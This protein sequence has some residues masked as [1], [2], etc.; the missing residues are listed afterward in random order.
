M[1]FLRNRRVVGQAITAAAT[2]LAGIAVSVFADQAKGNIVPHPKS[3]DETILSH[4]SNQLYVTQMLLAVLTV[5]VALSASVQ[6]LV[7][8]KNDFND[9]ALTARFVLDGEANESGKTYQE[10][11][12]LINEANES[13]YFVDYWV[14]TPNYEGEVQTES[15]AAKHKRRS[16]YYK[17]IERKIEEFRK[18]GGSKKHKRIIQV[19]A[20][21][22]GEID[23][24][25]DET[26]ATHIKTCLEIQ[27]TNAE[28]TSVRKADRSRLH[29]HFSIIDSTHIIWPILTIDESGIKRHGAILFEDASGD[30]V[31]CLMNLFDKLDGSANTFLAQDLDPPTT[32]SV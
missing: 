13:L 27:K 11:T 31:G 21:N 20:Q 24:S 22:H 9:R 17:A 2:F 30:L 29:T 26:F 5:V 8:L 18:G 4:L 12:R 6:F 7:I 14:Q 10:T 15:G 32:K 25:R 3:G 16:E 1:R 28:T 23:F 19:P